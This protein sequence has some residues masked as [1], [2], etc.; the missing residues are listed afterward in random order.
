MKRSLRHATMILLLAGSGAVHA[1]ANG[2]GGGSSVFICKILCEARYG[3]CT[4]PSGDPNIPPLKDPFCAAEKARCKDRCSSGGSNPGG[5]VIA[6]LVPTEPML[7]SP[8]DGQACE[9]LALFAGVD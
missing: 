1:A 2:G 6:Q 8:V 4:I 3:S 9:A 5:G 7:M